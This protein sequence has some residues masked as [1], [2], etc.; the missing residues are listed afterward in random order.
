MRGPSCRFRPDADHGAPAQMVIPTI[1]VDPP[2]L[3]TSGALGPCPVREHPFFVF[4]S[5]GDD[6]GP[7][8]FD[9]FCCH[10][11]DCRPLLTPRN[12]SL[13]FLG[14]LRDSLRVGAILGC[15][16]NYCATSWPDAR[17]PSNTQRPLWRDEAHPWGLQALP[18]KTLR[19]V[20]GEK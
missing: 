14:L 9:A 11:P 13:E 5:W 18:E 12:T 19:V 10:F 3:P 16:V 8:A 20:A 17:C 7:P 6:A 4:L 2:T 1:E 15:F